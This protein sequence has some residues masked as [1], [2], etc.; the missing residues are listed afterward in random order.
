MKQIA[1][2]CVTPISFD[3]EFMSLHVIF[4]FGSVHIL[5]LCSLHPTTLPY[6]FLAMCLHFPYMSISSTDLSIVLNCLEMQRNLVFLSFHIPF[7]LI[8]ITKF[9]IKRHRRP[10]FDRTGSE[11]HREDGPA[12]AEERARNSRTRRTPKEAEEELS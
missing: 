7:A 2:P 12:R 8:S 5:R 9:T 10:A 3:V 11:D 4:R 6:M 1:C